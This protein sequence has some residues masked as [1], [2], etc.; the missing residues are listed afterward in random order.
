MGL[1]SATL[2]PQRGRGC[3][4]SALPTLAPLQPDAGAPPA[5][6]GQTVFSSS[7]MLHPA[8]IAPRPPPKAFLIRESCIQ[9]LC[10]VP[11][12][13]L[14]LVAAGMILQESQVCKIPGGSWHAADRPCMVPHQ[15][16]EDISPL[17]PTHHLHSGLPDLSLLWRSSCSRGSRTQKGTW[18]S[19]A[20]HT[21]GGNALTWVHLALGVPERKTFS[22]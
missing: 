11:V 17:R 12:G 18:Q 8:G 6:E 7:H 2:P 13:V 1:L 10:F 4:R 5:G 9:V 15:Q 22:I 21:D 19:P 3:S 20:H 16:S 14:G